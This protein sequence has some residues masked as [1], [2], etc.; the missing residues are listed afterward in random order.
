M[1]F[2]YKEH[3]GIEEGKSHNPRGTKEN[4]D[5]CLKL[6]IILLETFFRREKITESPILPSFLAIR[7]DAA[8]HGLSGYKKWLSFGSFFFFS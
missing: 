2:P 8:S 1:L 5:K 6:T 3:I 4:L 7:L